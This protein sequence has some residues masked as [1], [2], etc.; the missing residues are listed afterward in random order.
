MAACLATVA[1]CDDVVVLD[2]FSTDDTAQIAAAHGARIVQREF[3]DFG[4]QRNFALEN[5]DFRHDWVFHLD[6]DERFNDALRVACEEVISR[7]ELSAYFVPNRVI[8]LGRWIRRSSLYPFPQVRLVKR[9]ELNFAK[10]GHGQKEDR[11]ERG[12]GHIVAPYDHYNF[13]KG[14]ADWVDKH[15]RYSSEEA[16]YAI[17]LRR[18]PLRL[19]EC[20]AS[21]VVRRRRAM[22]RIQARLP[23]RWAVKFVYLYFVR[24]GL[25]DGYPGLAYC[26]LH[27]FYE[28]LIAVKIREHLSQVRLSVGRDA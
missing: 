19:S 14:V 2:S 8:F 13:S 9:G 26:L 17:E 27:G 28:L 24:F 4:S 5:I 7:D 20:L 11:A 15:N 16:R 1:W 25:L 3:D 10:A 22:K 6:A 21:D 12:V 23:M 18:Q